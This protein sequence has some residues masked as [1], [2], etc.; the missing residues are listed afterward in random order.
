MRIGF[1][2]DLAAYGNKAGTILAATTSEND[3]ANVAIIT[4]SAFTKSLG[5]ASDL[6]PQLE[7]ESAE[8]I[9][10]TNLGPVTIDVPIDLQGLPSPD[11]ITRVWE[12]TRRPIDRAF[13]GLAP[14][15]DRL[16]Y[17]V[18][19]F[20]KLMAACRQCKIGE[21]I[22]ETYPAGSLEVCDLPHRKYKKGQESARLRQEIIEGLGIS[23]ISSEPPLSHDELD[24]VICAVTSIAEGDRLLHGAALREEMLKRLK[25]E[26]S[27]NRHQLPNGYRLLR[28]S[29]PFSS[30]SVSRCGAKK[31][32]ER[33]Q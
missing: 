2:I 12:L 10:L 32:F 23:M 28:R 27:G 9:R 14:L 11:N 18:A 16:G 17:C 31:W 4:D 30:I 19:R 8:L 26:A 21:T 5:G 7:Q 20:Q 33:H 24:A 6:L 22:F 25:K 1:G 15:A 13:N 29:K 3:C